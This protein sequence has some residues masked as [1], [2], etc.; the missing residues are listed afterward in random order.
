MV[1]ALGWL[2]DERIFLLS[3]P[4]LQTFHESGRE[5]VI[6]LISEVGSRRERLRSPCR[7][8]GD[9]SHIAVADLVLVLL[10]GVRLEP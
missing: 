7:A 2:E 9:R 4:H 8:S 5:S 6:D 3:H 1:S 10:Q